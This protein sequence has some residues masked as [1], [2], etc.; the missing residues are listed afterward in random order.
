MKLFSCMMFGADGADGGCGGDG[1]A[2]YRWLGD[3]GG[4]LLFYRKK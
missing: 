2:L 3:T 4:G 1:G